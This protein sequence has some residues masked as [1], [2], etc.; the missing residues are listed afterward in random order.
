MEGDEI[1]FARRVRIRRIFLMDQNSNEEAQFKQGY[2][3]AVRLLTASKKSSAELLNRLERKGYESNVAQQIVQKLKSQKVL[4][5]Q[6]LVQDTIQW[7]QETKH[8]GRNRLIQEFKKRGIERA[9][10]DEALKA[11][12]Q[13]KERELAQNLAYERWGQLG[14]LDFKKRTKRVYNYLVSRGFD[15][16]LSREIVIALKG[17]HD[18]NA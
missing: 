4:H 15:F 6:K 3:Y 16:E 1:K 2:L 9:L 18:D 17:A 12:P 8:L 10:I 11:L 7:A 13:A 14:K 5:D